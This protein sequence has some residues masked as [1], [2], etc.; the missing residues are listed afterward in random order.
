VKWRLECFE[1]INQYDSGTLTNKERSVKKLYE[2]QTALENRCQQ[3]AGRRQESWTL[4]DRASHMRKAGSQCAN[5]NRGCSYGTIDY[6][7]PT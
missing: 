2:A 3:G 1:E 6:I 5:S 4:T 7:C